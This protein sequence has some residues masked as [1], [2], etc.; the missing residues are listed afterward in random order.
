MAYLYNTRIRSKHFIFYRILRSDTVAF[1]QTG[2]LPLTME[3]TEEK[4]SVQQE[5]ADSLKQGIKDLG[6]AFKGLFGR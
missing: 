4:E 3:I 2:K 6:D 1:A 5:P